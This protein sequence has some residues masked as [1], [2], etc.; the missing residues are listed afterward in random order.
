MA[1]AETAEITHATSPEQTHHIDLTVRFDRCDLASDPVVHHLGLCLHAARSQ[2]SEMSPVC[3]DHVTSALQAYL[4]QA[5]NVV[6]LEPTAARGGLAPWQ[7]QRA[8][9]TLI[10][11]LDEPV[12]LSELARACKLSPGHFARAFRQTTGQP[13]HR[14]LM[15]QRIEKAKQLLVDTT[16][17]LAQ[18]A[19][20]CGF[21]D[22]SHFTR[23][24]AQLVQSSPGQWRRHWRKGPVA[25]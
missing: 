15:E 8:K 16:L 6:S 3:A 23:V 24:F 19:Q 17:S 5:H 18:I 2:P 20:T 7:L 14:W 21:A 10:S 1:M 13:P 11:R 9:Q 22:Q 12:S 4:K 25:A